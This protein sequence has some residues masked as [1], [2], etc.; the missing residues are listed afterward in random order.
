MRAETE[1]S[2]EQRAEREDSARA[3]AR[4]NP[5]SKTRF[6]GGAAVDLVSVREV[7]GATSERDREKTGREY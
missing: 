6:Y 4:A 5:T 3:R 2:S 7:E 1:V